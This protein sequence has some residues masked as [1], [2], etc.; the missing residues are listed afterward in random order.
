MA[1]FFFGGVETCV[2]F[3]AAAA[4]RIRTLHR[5]RIIRVALIRSVVVVPR[6]KK[7]V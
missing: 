7:K 4:V 5:G 3:A 2:T 6:A 1:G